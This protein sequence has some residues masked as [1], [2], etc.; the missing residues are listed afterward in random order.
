MNTQHGDSQGSPRI[1]DVRRAVEDARRDV[2]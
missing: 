1:D 2:L